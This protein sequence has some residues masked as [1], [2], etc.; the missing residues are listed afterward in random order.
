V[1]ECKNCPYSNDTNSVRNVFETFDDMSNI[2]YDDNQ[3][4]N[5]YNDDMSNTVYEENQSQIFY[6]N[7]NKSENEHQQSN[8]KSE[9]LDCNTFITDEN[10]QIIKQINAIIDNEESTQITNNSWY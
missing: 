9:Y 2:F 7:D 4:E 5:S 10:S 3:N 8:K 6:N 1:N